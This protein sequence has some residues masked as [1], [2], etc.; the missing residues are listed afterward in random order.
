LLFILKK[1]KKIMAL[2]NF[3]FILFNLLTINNLLKFKSKKSYLFG[4]IIF[5]YY[6]KCLSL[7]TFFI[8]NK[9]KE[10]IKYALILDFKNLKIFFT[11]LNLSNNTVILTI[12]S[13]II[14]NSLNIKVKGEKKINRNLVAIANF[15]K[16]NIIDKKKINNLIFLAKVS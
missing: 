9:K 12:T 11:L 4:I 16:K 2:N 15:V 5:N 13:K 14:L 8:G 10:K 3:F 6:I 7:V 1:K